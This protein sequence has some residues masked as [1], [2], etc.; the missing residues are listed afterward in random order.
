MLALTV[1]CFSF[2]KTQ[3]NRPN[4]GILPKID[5]VVLDP[6]HFHASLLQKSTLACVNDTVRVYAPKGVGLNQYLNNIDSYNHRIDN[7]THWHEIVYEG[8]DYLQKMLSEHKGN[9]VILAGNNQKKTKYILEAIKTGYNVLSD[10]PMAINKKNLKML[11]EAYQLAKKKNILLYDLMTE[12][13]DILN[14]VEKELLHNQDLFGKLQKG[15]SNHPGVIMESV[16]HF[17][18]NVSGKPVT[19]PAWYYDIEQQ[20]EGIADVTTHL[21]DLINWQCFPEKVIHY[22]S[23]IN[24][25]K[26]SH[27]PTYISLQEFN[28]STQVDSF[29]NYL[30]KYVKD[31]TLKVLANG[32]FYYTIKGVNVGIKVKWNYTPLNNGD[33]T[34]SS[35]KEGAKATLKIIQDKGSQF[36]R[37]LYIQKRQNILTVEFETQLQKAIKKIQ[38]IYPFVS[39][40]NK[41]NGL[42][43]I[44]I[45][46]KNRLGHEA[47][48]SKV[49]E[50]FF[51]YLQHRNIPK[52]ENEN[53]ISKYY[54][55]T[56][57]VELAQ[58]GDKEK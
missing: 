4:K 28:K 7:P 38:A 44:D 27:W 10:K 20:G 37:Q 57:A 17:F 3:G 41:S 40:K 8:N 14:I 35:I 50:R 21:I 33:D 56:S 5:L 46:L 24:V 54:I 31:S 12:R 6:G 47:L 16:H 32:S 58:R 43:L 25:L 48:F 15:T 2:S 55:T 39:I 11:I 29:P 18:K 23:D 51:Y 19:R 34:F 53:T 26:A 36:E 42:Y 1:P 52:W 22:Q 45:P 9:V 49:A 30:H 13:Y